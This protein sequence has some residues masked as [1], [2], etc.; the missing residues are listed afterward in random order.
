[1]GAKLAATYLLDDRPSEALAALN[2]TADA[3]ADAKT[4]EERGLL[5]ARA[6][7]QLNLTDDAISTLAAIQ[8]RDAARL[9][10]DVLWRARR[11]AMA[12][13]AIEA[14]L[15][16]P[17]A[18]LGDD[19]ARLVVNTAVAWKLAGD[20]ARLS[21]LKSRY[22]NAMAATALGPAFGV[23]TRD[24]GSASLSDRETILKIAGEVDM[25][26]GFL[27]AYQSSAEKGS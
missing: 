6:Q 15:P 2:K 21:S 20:A 25:F 13:E 9:K 26:K 18:K 3:P 8:S 10:A 24:G 17:S 7:S 4:R 14:L 16:P 5:R 19:E 12:A 23:V 27:D 11:W 22:Q 1:V